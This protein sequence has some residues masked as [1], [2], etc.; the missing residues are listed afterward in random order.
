[1]QTSD[2][3]PSEGSNVEKTGLGTKPF[4]KILPSTNNAVIQPE[5]N[6]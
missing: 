5:N 4:L 2:L 1:V 3:L 6:V